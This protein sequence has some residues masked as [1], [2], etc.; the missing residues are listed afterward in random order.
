MILRAQERN[1]T[2]DKIAKLLF[3]IINIS[4]AVVLSSSALADSPTVRAEQEARTERPTLIATIRPLALIAHDIAGDLVDIQVLLQGAVSPHDFSLT[5][6]Q[7]LALNDAD[8]VLWV[9][10]NIE[11][12]MNKGVRRK[13][14]LAMLAEDDHDDHAQ[15][16]HVARHPWLEMAAVEHY[17]ER[18]S[19]ALIT[20]LPHSEALLRKKQAAFVRALAERKQTISQSLAGYR[21]MPFLVHHDAYRGFVTD[22]GL[23]Q[24]YT[25]TR[26]PHERVSAKRL[27]AIAQQVPNLRCL[28]AEQGDE[29]HA[30][31]YAALLG[32]P[33]MTVD[34]L[35]KEERV[36]RF[37]DYLNRVAESFIAC[38]RAE[39]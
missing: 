19:E 18:L 31:R 35:A 11:A 22:Y 17:S 5:I 23:R 26:V 34:L 12:F 7:A 1:C 36:A 13:R 4:T 14:S 6:A 20:L 9:G 25:L 16:H 27:N 8:L 24:P 10:P 39:K 37:D 28:L 38:M 21:D 2:V 33:L 15:K 30:R 32:L 29:V 3:F